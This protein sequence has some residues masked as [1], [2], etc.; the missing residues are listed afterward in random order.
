MS[1]IKIRAQMKG[2][3]TEVKCLMTHPMETGQRKDEK[4][5]QLIPAHHINEVTCEHN[6]AAVLTCVWGPGVSKNPYLSFEFS[7]GKPGDKVKVSW[8][9]NKGETDTAEEAITAA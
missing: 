7:G 1:G 3:A 4:T 2:D 6:G 9:D 5:G 8:V